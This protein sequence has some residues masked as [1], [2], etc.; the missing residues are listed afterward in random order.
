MAN[1]I[2]ITYLTR[3]GL[4]IMVAIFKWLLYEVW[5]ELRR[6]LVLSENTFIKTMSGFQ[7]FLG[8]IPHNS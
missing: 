6:G 7:R 5:N 4:F 3:C 8:S 2:T 1:K